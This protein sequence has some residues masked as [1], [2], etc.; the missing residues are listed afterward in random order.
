MM[1]CRASGAYSLAE[2]AGWHVVDTCFW[3]A[4]FTS[5]LRYRGDRFDDVNC[6]CYLSV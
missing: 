5:T 2:V 1:A 4:T 6:V 3:Q